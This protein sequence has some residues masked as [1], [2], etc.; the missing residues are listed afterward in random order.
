ME[1]FA[2]GTSWRGR[3]RCCPSSPRCRT[4]G[5]HRRWHRRDRTASRLGSVD[6]TKP[7]AVRFVSVADPA[8]ASPPRSPRKTAT[9]VTVT[10][11]TLP[12]DGEYRVVV[13]GRAGDSMPNG[14]LDVVTA[15][16]PGTWSRRGRPGRP[17]RQGHPV[18]SGLRLRR[19]VARLAAQ[20][21]P[22]PWAARPPR[23]WISDTQVRVTVPD[24]GG[25]TDGADRHLP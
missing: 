25:R 11:P 23:G 19:D 4:R 22:R 5:V 13:A 15:L 16:R 8:V 24:R 18:S 3:T 14:V 17:Q 20:S 21:S 12:A 1:A 6:T 2:V 9:T 10:I 7:G